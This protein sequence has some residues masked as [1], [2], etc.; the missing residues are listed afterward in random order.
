MCDSNCPSFLNNKFMA[1]LYVCM[2]SIIIP[3]I[4]EQ[5]NIG[6]LIH[7]LRQNSSPIIQEIIIVNGGSGD[8]TINSARNA[9]ATAILLPQ[10]GRANDTGLADLPANSV[11][12][13][14][15]LYYL[16][17]LNEHRNKRINNSESTYKDSCNFYGPCLSK[18]KV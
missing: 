1:V 15:R 4:N 17:K 8:D 5:D 10:K 11:Y 9:R 7:Y 18:D 16:T 2:L 3:T 6:K 12:L 13:L 14:V